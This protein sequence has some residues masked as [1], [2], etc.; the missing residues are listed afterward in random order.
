LLREQ[1]QVMRRQLDWFK[2]Q[3]FGP[4]SE[5]Q[6]YDLPEQDSLFQPDEVPEQPAGE[7]KRIIKAYQRGTAGKQRNDDCLNDTGLRFSADVPVEVIEHLPPELTGP[8][9]DQYEV[10][11]SKTTYRLA[12]RASSYV[13]LKLERPVFRRKG[14][15]QP[16]TTPALFNV[17][18]NSLADTSLLAGLLVDKFQ[19]HLP[20]YRQHQRIQQA[21]VT[22]SRSTLTNLVSAP[23]ICCAPLWMRRPVTCCAAGC[24]PWTKRPSRPVNSVG[25]ARK[26]AG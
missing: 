1:L 23:S 20:L 6:V 10:I 16:V 21:G 5:K 9:A 12:Q 7:A 22:V 8:E 14:T 3:L 19:F 24:W 4:K 15:E 13:V 26:K 11:G 25:Q 2:K 18:D 17:L